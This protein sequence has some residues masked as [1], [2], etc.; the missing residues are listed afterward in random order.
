VFTV[1]AARVCARRDCA[2]RLVMSQTLVLAGDLFYK[3]PVR[4]RI[5]HPMRSWAA[6]RKYDN[7]SSP[8]ASDAA[9]LSR[10]LSY[11]GLLPSIPP[12]L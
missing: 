1:G 12:D 10:C 9:L 7:N 2:E 11:L 8:R 5:V 4:S 3:Q 6:S